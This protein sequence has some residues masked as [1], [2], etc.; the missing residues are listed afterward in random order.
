DSYS[1]LEEAAIDYAEQHGAVVVAAVGNGDQAPSMPWSYASYPAALPHVLGVGAL[2]PDGSVPLFSNRDAVYEDLAA[3]GVQMFS[4]FPRALTAAQRPACAEQ[5]YSS[6]AS[7]DY[8]E[9]EGTSFAAPQVS[10]AAA[11]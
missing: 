9:A 10:A 3:P 7:P 4:T 8:R 6:C 11:L 5:G 2:A 1:P